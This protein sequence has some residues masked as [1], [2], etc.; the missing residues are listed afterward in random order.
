MTSARAAVHP[1][2]CR[3]ACPAAAEHRRHHDRLLAVD[4]DVDAVV[5]LFE[6][7]VTWHEL[8]WSDSDVV[9]P[10]HWAGFAAAHDWADPE[11]AARVFGLAVDIVGP[12]ALGETAAEPATAPVIPLVRR[13]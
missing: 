2:R 7:A 6:I 10:R 5:E 13:A 9:A 4:T 11:R 8:D 12:A 1:L 3:G